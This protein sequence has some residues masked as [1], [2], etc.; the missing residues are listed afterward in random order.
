MCTCAS[1]SKAK[2]AILTNQT[3]AIIFSLHLRT[4]ISMDGCGLVTKCVVSA[5]QRG[6][7]VLATI[8][9]IN[10]AISRLEGQR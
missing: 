1:T 7:A 8:H 6:D 5:F 3:N 2:E 10:G 9:F 4:I